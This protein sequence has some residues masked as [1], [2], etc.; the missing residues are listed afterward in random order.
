MPSSL[1]EAV[2]NLLHSIAPI[3]REVKSKLIEDVYSRYQNNVLEKIK[4]ILQQPRDEQQ[5]FKNLED[6]LAT[7]W[8]LISGTALSYTALPDDKITLLLCDIA[9]LLAQYSR[10]N[11]NKS[12]INFLMPTVA[13]ESLSDS[14]PSLVELDIRQVLKSH[15]LGREGKYLIPAKQLLTLI[16]APKTERYNIYYDYEIH[17]ESFAVLSEEEYERIIRHSPEAGALFSAY[18]QHDLCINEQGSLLTHLHELCRHLRFNSIDGVG[19]EKLPGE[20]AYAAI[21]QFANYYNML[22]DGKG[23]IPANVQA[24]IDKL[25]ALASDPSQNNNA[26]SADNIETCIKLRRDK[27]EEVLRPAEQILSEIGVGGQQKINLIDKARQHIADCEHA[28]EKAIDQCSYRG[29]DKLG[30]TKALADKLN[31]PVSISSVDDLQEF[32]KLTPAEISHFCQDGVIQKQV[33]D[34]FQSIEVLIA[35]ICDTAPA[36][37]EALFSACGNGLAKKLLV[38][39]TDF[40]ALVMILS[41]ERF[42]IVFEAMK[43]SLPRLIKNADDFRNVLRLLPSEQ[44]TAVCETMKS[45]LPGFIAVAFGFSFLLELLSVEQRGVVFE[46]MKSSLPKI[47]R[48]TNDFELIAQ[49]LEEQQRVALCNHMPNLHRLV[50]DVENDFQKMSNLFPTKD[51]KQQFQQS[52]LNCLLTDIRAHVNKSK[53]SGSKLDQLCD[54]LSHTT[55]EFFQNSLTYEVFKNECQT[56]VKEMRA[57]LRG[58]DTVLNMLGKWMLAIATLGT[59]VAISTLKTRV[60]TGK[61]NC[62]FFN[63]KGE[64]E[65]DKVLQSVAIITP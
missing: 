44:C 33:V 22:E 46:T 1:Y 4:A 16:T 20:G 17:D 32:M 41:R 62:Y 55:Q 34:Q 37:L 19:Q 29:T 7:N 40:S 21:I 42:Q 48:S 9:G 57:Y 39:P 63:T 30:I 2:S 26:T 61:W 31:A 64:Q 13:I 36:K 50:V 54:S 28:L 25:I 51:Y 5:L 24:E 60:E 53:S 43:D 47:I 23:K 11:E 38:G 14:Y 65:A 10:K 49:N 6:L 35:F 45:S 56:Q 52:Y 58:Q 18:T 12:V 59:A 8:Q 27:L 3:Q 15:V